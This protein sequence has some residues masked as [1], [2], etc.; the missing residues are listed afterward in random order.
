MLKPAKK[1]FFF[2]FFISTNCGFKIKPPLGS[3]IEDGH[4]K[5]YNENIKKALSWV[6]MHCLNIVSFNFLLSELSN[7]M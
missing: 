5:A 2:H 3:M 1:D 7:K 6:L 4:Q